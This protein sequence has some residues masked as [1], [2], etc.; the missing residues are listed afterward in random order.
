MVQGPVPAKL[1]VSPFRDLITFT[2]SPFLTHLYVIRI[3]LHCKYTTFWLF[4][5][6][7][8][9]W[10]Q[11]FQLFCF[12]LKFY[13]F[14]YILPRFDHIYALLW[15][16]HSASTCDPMHA[17]TI[18]ILMLMPHDLYD[19]ISNQMEMEVEIIDSVFHSSYSTRHYTTLYCTVRAL[20]WF[21][22]LHL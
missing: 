1:L 12:N 17:D 13:S 4:V 9:W 8:R 6:I 11:Y 14:C 22:L 20:R 3:Q 15:T 10:L 19:I 7:M 18:L 2:E 21:Q 5:R 16:A